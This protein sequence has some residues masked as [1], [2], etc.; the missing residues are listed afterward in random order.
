MSFFLGHDSLR[1]PK[2]ECKDSDKEKLKGRSN[3]NMI[4]TIETYLS[5]IQKSNYRAKL[6]SEVLFLSYQFLNASCY[7][8]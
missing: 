8:P 5:L 4:E 1:I 2:L 6:D 7:Q 3:Q